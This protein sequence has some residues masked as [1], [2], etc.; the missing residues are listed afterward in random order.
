MRNEIISFTVGVVVGVA[1]SFG[2]CLVKRHPSAA[3]KTNEHLVNA[4]KALD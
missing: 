3:K 1:A 4:E 2:Y